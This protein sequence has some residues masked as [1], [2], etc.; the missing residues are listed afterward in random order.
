MRGRSARASVASGQGTTSVIVNYGCAAVSDNVTV[1]P[2]NANGCNGTPSSLAVTVTGVDTAGAISG[3]STLCA[4]SNGVAYSISNVNGATTYAWTAPAGTSIASGQGS[5][6]ITVNWGSTS[7]LVESHARQCQWVQRHRRHPLGHGQP[8]ADSVQCNWWWFVLRCRQPGGCRLGWIAIGCELPTV[9]ERQP[10][11][12]ADGGHGLGVVAWQSGGGG[13]LHGGGGRRNRRLHCDHGRS[14][15]V[16]LMDPFL[17]WQLQYFGCTNCPQADAAAD[18][19]GDG[20]NNMAEFLAGTI[21]TNSASVLRITSLAR[22]GTDI[23]VT[24]STAGVTPISCK[25]RMA[26]TIR[27]TSWTSLLLRQSSAAAGTKPP[28]TS[29]PLVPRTC[30]PASTASGSSRDIVVTVHLCQRLPNTSIRS[31]KF[32]TGMRK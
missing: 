31:A 13:Q 23:A 14:A 8:V 18:P 28:I 3:L 4:G 29:T 20:Q 32:Q 15:T 10:D 5:T 25:P 11:R 7:G 26:V 27:I 19:D 17:C 9:V 22:S 12:P 6:S 21:P 1:T 16:T 2:V 24:W 30:P